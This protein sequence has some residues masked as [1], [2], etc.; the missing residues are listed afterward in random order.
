LE[1]PILIGHPW[2]G[3]V[4][5]EYG[6]TYTTQCAALVLVDGGFLDVGNHPKMSWEQTQATLAPLDFINVTEQEL[7]ERMQQRDLSI[8]WTEELLNIRMAGFYIDDGGFT[9]PRLPRDRYMLI[10]Q[11]LREQNPS[12]LYGKVK[13]PVLLIPAW[14]QS[15]DGRVIGF[16][17]NK[18]HQLSI[19]QE[20]LIKSHRT[21]MKNTIH[22]IPLQ[23]PQEL[24]EL[25]TNF[26][27]SNVNS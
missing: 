15:S 10:L 7:L 22:D 23:K 27:K 2:G 6:A 26:I 25:I 12:N 17:E 24:A 19:A 3:N 1:Q 11:A 20:G 14:I 13:C 16:Q 9:H 8:H 5:L 21:D 18:R 4:A